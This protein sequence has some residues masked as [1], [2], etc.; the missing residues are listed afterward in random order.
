MRQ[1]GYYHLAVASVVVIMF[2]AMCRYDD[3][4]GLRWRNIR[5]VGDGSGIEISECSGMPTEVATTVAGLYRWVGRRARRMGVQRASSREEPGKDFAGAR[6]NSYDQMLRFVSL[7]FS[8]VL[9]PSV[10]MFNKQFATK[11]GWSG[12]ASAAANSG[13]PVEL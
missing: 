1:Q 11:S 12:S 10:A 13:V 6:A 5:F 2:G 3:A 8:G 4:S 9:G 7:W